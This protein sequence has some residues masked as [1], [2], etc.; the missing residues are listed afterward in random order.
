MLK[1]IKFG[2]VLI[3]MLLLV[4]VVMQNKSFLIDQTNGLD[5]NLLVTEYEIPDQPMY[6]LFFGLFPML[7]FC[8]PHIFLL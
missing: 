6:A 2:I 1:N 5:I 8:L 7:V 3:I 4:I